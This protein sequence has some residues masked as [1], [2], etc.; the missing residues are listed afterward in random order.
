MRVIDNTNA[1]LS[2]CDKRIQ[3]CLVKSCIV[4]EKAAKQGCPRRTGNLARSITSEIEGKTGI[5]GTNVEYAPIVEL[6]SRPHLITPKTKKALFW[7]G[8]EHPVKVVHH[9]GT[10]PH[11]FLRVALE[12]S[13]GRIREIFG[14]Y[15]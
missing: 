2:E 1:V 8:A 15:Q 6:G 11:S 14:A 12:S 3:D 7:S 10:K 5:V 13:I 4:V 9:P